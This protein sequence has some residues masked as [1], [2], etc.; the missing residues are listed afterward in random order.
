MSHITFQ[1]F[2][3]LLR[4][5]HPNITIS[6]HNMDSLIDTYR[7]SERLTENISLSERRRISNQMIYNIQQLTS[8]NNRI[9]TSR[10]SPTFDNS[11][12]TPPRSP[13]SE[14]FNAPISPIPRMNSERNRLP[15]SL[16]PSYEIFSP[17]DVFDSA[18]ET[19]NNLNQQVN[20]LLIDEE[21][22]TPTRVEVLT[23][24]GDNIT[25]NEI[26]ELRNIQEGESKNPNGGRKRRRRKTK[27]RKRRKSKK[28]RRK[29]SK[30]N[31]KRRKR[32]TKKRR[33]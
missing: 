26:Q 21:R 29:K 13:R 2:V 7:L 1:D 6:N 22:R 8:E 10:T 18:L 14:P 24:R 9:T 27:K 20:Q 33:K 17:I 5:R 15:D 31:R 4:D 11:L 19:Q 23:N 32:K 3:D 16:Q 28:I 25:E 12:R 30:K